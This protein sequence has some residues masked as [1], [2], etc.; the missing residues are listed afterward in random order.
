[1]LI[2]LHCHSKYSH[3]NHL[4][5]EDLIEKAMEVGLNGVCFTE[6]YSFDSSWPIEKMR[7]PEN[8]LV[9]RGWKSRQTV[10]IFSCMALRTI[11][12]IAGEGTPT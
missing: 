4:E 5:P 2:D 8:F 6:H 7:L 12:G 10:V 1:M 9:L 3:D 11:P